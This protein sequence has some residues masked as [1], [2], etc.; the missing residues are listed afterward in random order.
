MQ[1]TEPHPACSQGP[2]ADALPLLCAFGFCVR[3]AVAGPTRA[4]TQWRCNAQVGVN[5]TTFDTECELHK[6]AAAHPATGLLLRIRADDKAALHTMGNKYGAEAM[7]TFNLLSCARRLGL[8]VT[9]V[10]FH[11]GS[12]ASNP[13]AFRDAITLARQVC[14]AQWLELACSVP[15]LLQTTI[16]SRPVGRAA[17]HLRSMPA[18]RS[19]VLQVFDQGAALGFSMTLLDLGGGYP[20]GQWDAQGHFNLLP[21]AAAVNAALDQHFPADSGISIIAEP[22]RFFAGMLAAVSSSQPWQLVCTLFVGPRRLPPM[23]SLGTSICQY[24]PRAQAWLQRPGQCI[25]DKLTVPSAALLRQHL[26]TTTKQ[27]MA[28][29]RTVQHDAAWTKRI[30]AI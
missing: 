30:R 8:R 20:G 7:D 23:H 2:P 28:P 27:R 19:P 14:P 1:A 12:G 16:C 3:P 9:G 26:P 6:L 5:L 21:V 11:V 24:G 17:L 25:S 4:Q 13:E 10:S 15:C 29:V 22:G 18:N